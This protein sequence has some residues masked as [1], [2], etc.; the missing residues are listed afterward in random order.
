MI[1]K[2]PSISTRRLIALLNE[3]K[4]KV[5]NKKTLLKKENKYD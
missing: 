5:N 4:D 2:L 3:E 1:L